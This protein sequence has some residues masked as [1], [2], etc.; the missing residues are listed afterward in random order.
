MKDSNTKTSE[1]NMS[2]HQQTQPADDGNVDLPESSTPDQS[3][4]HSEVAKAVLEIIFEHTANKFDAT[5]KWLESGTS[6]FLTV[7]DTFVSIEAPIEACLPAFPFKSAN[8]EYKVLG[9]L[10]DKAEELALGRL[11]EM[12]DRIKEI[13]PPGAS[14]MIISDGITYNGSSK[15]DSNNDTWSSNLAN[16]FL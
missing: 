9:A 5:Q 2:A 1:T 10:P 16:S 8:K 13:Y 15:I 11:N 12:C 3:Q 7:I 14:V 6:G 4:E